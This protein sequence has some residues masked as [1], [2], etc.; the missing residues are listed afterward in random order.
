[1]KHFRFFFFIVSIG[2]EEKTASM[3]LCLPFNRQISVIDVYIPS[4][5]QNGTEMQ[6]TTLGCNKIN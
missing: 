1:M 5:I 3:L 4:G 2:K 6:N